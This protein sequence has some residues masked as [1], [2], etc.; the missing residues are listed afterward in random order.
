MQSEYNAF[1]AGRL[2]KC[3]GARKA[4]RSYGNKHY[5]GCYGQAMVTNASRLV[6]NGLIG[7][8]IV[9]SGVYLRHRRQ[10]SSTKKKQLHSR[11]SALKPTQI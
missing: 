3:K 2:G 8:T 7:A 4:T 5:Y 11:I 6:H 10:R 9:A 1:I